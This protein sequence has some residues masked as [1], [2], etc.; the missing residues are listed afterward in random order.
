MAGLAH[1][2]AIVT[3]KGRLTEPLWE[4]SGAVALAPAGDEDALLREV[5]RL[6][7]SPKER[8]RLSGA[9]RTLYRERFDLSHT[10]AA[11][12]GEADERADSPRSLVERA[13]A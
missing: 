12:R 5:R 9:A 3:T 8:A 10:I 11:L 6:L 4:E 2:L 1:G 7:A 13:E